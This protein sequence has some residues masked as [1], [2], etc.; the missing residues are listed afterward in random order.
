MRISFAWL[1]WRIAGRFITPKPLHDLYCPCCYYDG[2]GD[3]YEVGY[4]VFEA[5][6]NPDTS[7]G[8]GDYWTVGIQTCPRCLYSFQLDG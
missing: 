4:E 6:K 2:C 5:G 1:W 8:Y 7:H 3:F